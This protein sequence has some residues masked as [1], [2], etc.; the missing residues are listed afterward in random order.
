MGRRPRPLAPV[1]AF[2]ALERW[3]Q[4]LDEWGAWLAARG[5]AQST[6]EQYDSALVRFFRRSRTTPDRL[7]E[8]DVTAFLSSIDP[9]GSAAQLYLRALKAYY[10][11]TV[12]PQVAL[13]EDN[14]VV[15][16]PLR[17]RKYPEPDFYTAPEF[18]AIVA[19]AR[20]RHERRAQAITLLLETGTRIGALAHVVPADTGTQAGERIHFRVTKSDRP[21]SVIL[22]PAAARAVRWLLSNRPTRDAGTLVGVHKATIWQWFHQAAVDAGLP[23]E[24]DHPHLARHTAA[25]N[26]YRRTK[27]PMLVQRFLNHADLSLIHRY[28]GRDDQAEAEA[29][30]VDSF[31]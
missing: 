26:L 27:D 22:T 13:H 14:P 30:A 19:A 1:G 24:R 15:D 7:T 11:Y 2:D 8:A 21:Y 29:M 31:G 6:I 20:A 5:V 4:V 9:R 16:L 3:W 23:P 25:T 18:A 28:A 12:R 17:Q 10:R